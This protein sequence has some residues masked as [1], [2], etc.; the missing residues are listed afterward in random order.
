MKWYGSV[1]NRIA[2]H[3]IPTNYF[4]GQGVTQ[5]LWSD[6]HAYYIYSIDKTDK[7]G[8][9]EITL[10]RP[11]TKCKDWYAGDWEVESFEDAKKR[12]SEKTQ[13]T[14]IKRTRRGTFT[15]TGTVKGIVFSIGYASEYKDPSF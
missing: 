15:D 10:I 1:Q 4:V 6:C 3:I 2:E 9:K 7:K 5:V 14:K 12:V 11:I 13:F 8:P